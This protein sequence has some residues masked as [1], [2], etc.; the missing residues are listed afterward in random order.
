[1]TGVTLLA[2]RVQTDSSVPKRA[3]STGGS[4]V[5]LVDHTA[6][7]VFNSCALLAPT[8]LRKERNLRLMDAQFVHL[9]TTVPLEPNTSCSHLAP[10]AHTVHKDPIRLP[11]LQVLHDQN[12]SVKLLVTAQPVLL[13]RHAARVTL[14]E[15]RPANLATTALAVF[16][17]QAY[18]VLLERTVAAR[19]ARSTQISA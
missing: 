8:E 19:Q 2:P 9:V 7:Q 16:Q 3:S 11:V 1:M 10:Q 15:A 4:R 18:L 13:A 6:S 5:V 12:Y 17:P 14:L